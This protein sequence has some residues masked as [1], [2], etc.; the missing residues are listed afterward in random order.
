MN[1]VGIRGILFLCRGAGSRN[2]TGTVSLPADFESAASTNFAT[3]ATS[4]YYLLF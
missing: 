1:L 3:P 2:R 4:L